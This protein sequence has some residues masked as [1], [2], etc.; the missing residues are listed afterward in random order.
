MS[1]KTWALVS[2][3]HAVA[4]GVLLSQR[5]VGLNVGWF[6]VLELRI[7]MGPTGYTA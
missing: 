4:E 7:E 5:E 6:D 2:L 1:G 3:K